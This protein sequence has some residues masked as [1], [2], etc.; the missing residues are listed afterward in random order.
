MHDNSFRDDGENEQD[1]LENPY[2]SLPQ[3]VDVNKRY[4]KYHQD[5]EVRFIGRLWGYSRTHV[6]E[7]NVFLCVILPFVVFTILFRFGL[8]PLGIMLGA[9]WASGGLYARYAHK[10]MATAS[11][12]LAQSINAQERELIALVLRDLADTDHSLVYYLNRPLQSSDERIKRLYEECKRD[13]HEDL[14]ALSLNLISG[15]YCYKVY[16]AAEFLFCDMQPGSQYWWDIISTG[17][18]T[19][20]GYL[21]R[22][23][24]LER[25]DLAALADEN[26]EKALEEQLAGL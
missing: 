19:Y 3:F 6:N 20:K 1:Q 11:L 4:E 2:P 8:A 9:L 10:R 25:S 13:L 26:E 12:T 7:G 18:T 16:A 5:T 24:K 21:S 22:F 14:R 17:Q 15:K 23:A